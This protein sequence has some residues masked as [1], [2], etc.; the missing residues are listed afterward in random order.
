M[1]LS[2]IIPQEAAAL[3]PALKHY[4]PGVAFEGTRDVRVVDHAKTL[5]VAIWLHR[6]DMAVGGE[7]LAS[8]TLE[9]SRHCL[10]PLL[11]SFL[12]PRTSNLTFQ[13]VVDCVLKENHRASEQSLHHLKG[14]HVHDRE[15]LE[16][17]IKAHRELDKMDKAARK[18]LKK[19]IDQRRKSLEALKKCIS[20]YETQ[21][22]QEP[23]EGNAP[24]DDGQ[25]GHSAQAEMAPTLGANDAPSESTMTPATPASDP[26]PAEDQTQDM[27]VDDFGTHLHLPSPVS[28][29]DDDLLLGLPQS[30]VTEVELGLAHLTVSS[31]WGPNGEG[32]EA[33]I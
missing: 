30:E 15:V 29:E 24:D 25:A 3:L 20:Y 31:P 11:G 22:G 7:V 16:G 4:V 27:E 17:L 6:L 9:A 19:E 33:S 23:S 13:E 32:E 18:S 28:R 10:G 2:P 26:S 21:L 12:T 5:Q 1:T 8:E 14:C